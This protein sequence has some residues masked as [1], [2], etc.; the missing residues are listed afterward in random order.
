MTNGSKV[1]IYLTSL[2]SS[3]I[4]Y[5]SKYKILPQGKIAK[6]IKSELSNRLS[7]RSLPY[8]FEGKAYF[9]EFAE[10]FS[11]FNLNHHSTSTTSKGLSE[12]FKKLSWD[13]SVFPI[14]ALVFF[15]NLFRVIPKF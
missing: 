6:T 11:K 10:N 1:L 4:T 2:F 14:H 9:S 3:C 12:K 5:N 7:Y 13:N 15:A 8:L